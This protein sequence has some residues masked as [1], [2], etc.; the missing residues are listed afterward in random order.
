MLTLVRNQLIP[1]YCQNGI[2]FAVSAVL[3]D[4]IKIARGGAFPDV[5]VAPQVLLSCSDKEQGCQSGDQ[6]YAWEYI[7]HNNITDET[8]SVFVAGGH[9]NGETCSS[10]RR[11]KACP[12]GSPCFIPPAYYEYGIKEYSYMFGEEEIRKEV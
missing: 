6:S 10:A 3:S 4:R 1:R 5:H 11:C 12:V 7:K 8:C 9:D 2:A